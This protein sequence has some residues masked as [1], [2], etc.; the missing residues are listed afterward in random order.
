VAPAE[1]NTFGLLIYS[2]NGPQRPKRTSSHRWEEVRGTE[3]ERLSK[4]KFRKTYSF[5]IFNIYKM[6]L[7]WFLNGEGPGFEEFEDF[8]G[9]SVSDIHFLHLMHGEGRP[10]PDFL[11]SKSSNICGNFVANC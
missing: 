1:R 3:N 11:P 9:I 10:G 2:A 5:K 6:S 8:V 4:S 7:F